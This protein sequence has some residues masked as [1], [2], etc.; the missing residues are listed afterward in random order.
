MD[1]DSMDWG[2]PSPKK[3]QLKD[4]TVRNTNYLSQV[5]VD[6]RNTLHDSRN[7][8]EL[9]SIASNLKEVARIRNEQH[10]YMTTQEDMTQSSLLGRT[11]A[12]TKNFTASAIDAGTQIVNQAAALPSFMSATSAKA[13]VDDRGRE[14]YGRYKK[15]PNSIT[16][17]ELAYLNGKSEKSQTG[18]LS[19]LMA[20]TRLENM[21][22]YDA[23]MEDVRGWVG[24]AR[25][26]KKGKLGTDLYNPYFSKLRDEEVKQLNDLTASKYTD[27][28]AK[29]KEMGDIAGMRK[30]QAEMTAEMLK[31][32]VK[33]NAKHNDALIG[34]AGSMVP[35]LIGGMA[36]AVGGAGLQTME[37]YAHS[38]D[39]YEKREGHIP[40]GSDGW[41]MAGMAG[42]NFG[43]NFIEN[44]TPLHALKAIRK[45]VAP[46]AIEA[47]KGSLAKSSAVALGGVAGATASNFIAGGVQD[48]IQRG[49]G[50]L[51]TDDVT[52]RSFIEAAVPAGLTGGALIAG[53][54]AVGGAAQGLAV[55]AE[56]AGAKAKEIKDARA[57]GAFEEQ[58]NPDSEKFN[59]LE[60]LQSQMKTYS[61]DN[62]TDE[63]KQTAFAQMEQAINAAEV[64]FERTETEVKEAIAQQDKNIADTKEAIAEFSEAIKVTTDVEK[65]AEYKTAIAEME[66][67]IKGYEAKRE[68][69]NTLLET[70]KADTAQVYDAYD[71]FVASNLA[72][73]E[74]AKAEQIVSQNIETLV[75]KD[76]DEK[77]MAK[78]VD[79]LKRNTAKYSP[80]QLY[81][82]AESAPSLSEEARASI[83][84]LADRKVELNSKKD[85]NAVS[86]EILN[87][88][89]GFIGLNEYIDKIATARNLG[90]EGVVTRN[91]SMLERFE[92]GAKDKANVAKAAF[93]MFQKD[94]QTRQIYKTA[95]NGAWAI[96]DGS[97]EI[98]A[99]NRAKY[100]AL[101]IG[102]N[103]SKLVS[104][105]AYDANEIAK[106]RT[107][108][109]GLKAF[110]TPAPEPVAA[111]KA[112]VKVETPDST[113]EVQPA[114]KAQPEGIISVLKDVTKE[115]RTAERNKAY[116][117]Q[118][119]IRTGFRQKPGNGL[120]NPL[121]AR[122]DFVSS[123]N[124]ET[125]PQAIKETTG[126]DA[127]EGR[128]KLLK[129][130]AGFS[131][132]FR[133]SLQKTFFKDKRS[134]FHHNDFVQ[135]LAD[136]NGQFDENVHSA[137]SLSAYAWLAEEGDAPMMRDTD[138]LEGIFHFTNVDN[139]FVPK[140][141]SQ[142]FGH[143]RHLSTAA[144]DFGKRAVS[145]LGLKVAPDAPASFQGRLE[146]SMGVQIVYAMQRAG[147]VTI[148]TKTNKEMAA[149]AKSL[150][151]SRYHDWLKEF[152][153][154]AKLPRN[155]KEYTEA[156]RKAVLAIENDSRRVQKF[157][158]PVRDEK[159]QAPKA[160]Q[161]IMESTR[162]ERGISTFMSEMF[163]TAPLYRDPS[164]GVPADASSKKQ[165]GTSLDISTEQ[166]KRINAAQKHPYRVR[167]EAYRPIAYMTDKYFDNFKQM[168]GLEV[169]REK[170][171]ETTHA[172]RIDSKVAKNEAIL[173]DLRNARD[174]IDTELKDEKG[175]YADTYMEMNVVRTQRM[176]VDNTRLNTQANQVHRAIVTP[177]DYET[178]V[179]IPKGAIK[180]E[181]TFVQGTG[182]VTQL[183]HFLRA[184]AENAEE[185]D[186][187]FAN[188]Y[189]GSSVDKVAPDDFLKSF[190]DWINLPTTQKGI[191]AMVAV[192]DH[193]EKGEDMSVSLFDDMAVVVD[194]MGMGVQSLNGLISLAEMQK[195]MKEG[196]DEFTTYTRAG[197]DGKTNGSAIAL[198]MSGTVDASTGTNDMSDGFGLIT[199]ASNADPSKGFTSQY[200]VAKS[201]MGDLY[202][203]INTFQT[204]RW[205]Q[206]F[207]GNE[208]TPT[209]GIDALSSRT[210][211]AMDTLFGGFNK[212]AKGKTIASPTIYG[213]GVTALKVN[214]ENENL[215]TLYSQF[216]KI[217]AK[218]KTDPKTAH[219]M[220]RELEHNV[221]Q[222]IQFHNELLVQIPSSESVATA[223][224]W[225]SRL[226]YDY[227]LRNP[228]NP[229]N[230]AQSRESI[231][232]QYA[233][234]YE[235]PF[236]DV[237]DKARKT[238]NRDRSPAK[239]GYLNA[240]DLDASR[241]LTLEFDN[242][243]TNA[244]GQVTY[245]THGYVH[246]HAL[247]DAYKDYLNVRDVSIA[248]SGVAYKVYEELKK[249][250]VERVTQEG[251]EDG[252]IPF[253]MEDG[254]RVAQVGLSE[255]AL[256]QVEKEL[257]M[258]RP[259]VVSAM[260]S[261]SKDPVGTGIM[262][263]DTKAVS[264]KDSAHFVNS[265]VNSVDNE[266]KASTNE[267]GVKVYTDG[268][269]GVRI[270]VF[271]VLGTDATISSSTFNLDFAV[272]NMHDANYGPLDK[273]GDLGRQQNQEFHDTAATYHMQVEIMNT[274]MRSLAHAAK[275]DSL[276]PESW[277]N[278]RKALQQLELKA[279]GT[280]GKVGIAEL[281][282]KITDDRYA[283]EE[284]K[285]DYLDSLHTIHQY[286]AL[287]GQVV[288][289]E[290]H[291]ATRDAARKALRAERKGPAESRLVTVTKFLENRL[292]NKGNKT[293]SSPEPKE[294]NPVLD[295]LEGLGDKGGDAKEV[296]KLLGKTFNKNKALRQLVDAMKDV[297]GDSISIKLISETDSK[298]GPESVA[299]YSLK[300]NA[301]YVVREGVI[302]AKDLEETLLHEM[303]HATT[304]HTIEAVKAG[305][306]SEEA[307]A[308]YDRLEKLRNDIIAQLS[309]LERQAYDHHLSDVHELVAYGLSDA[310]FKQMLASKTVQA[311]GRT[312]SS[313]FRNLVNAILDLAFGTNYRKANRT[314]LPA[315]E[316]LVM[317]VSHILEEGKTRKNAL[318]DFEESVGQV[319]KV[320]NQ[321]RE[322]V[323]NMSA[324][325]VFRALPEGN[326]SPAFTKRLESLLGDVADR[327][328][329]KRPELADKVSDPQTRS[330]GALSAGF[331][332][333]DR[334]A[335]AVEVFEA[336]L[337]AAME[338]GRSTAVMRVMTSTYNEARKSLKPQDFLKGDWSTASAL[339]K[340]VAQAQYNYLFKPST[341][342]GRNT[343]IA[344][345][346]AMSMGSEKVAEMMNFVAEP[347][348]ARE[349]SLFGKLMKAVDYA[350]SW[351]SNWIAGARRN[352]TVNQ[353]AERLAIR[354]AEID[355]QQRN[356]VLRYFEN[357][358]GWVIGKLQ[359]ADAG[360]ANSMA[361]LSDLDSVKNSR[362]SLVRTFGK[363]MALNG[364]ERIDG[365][366]KALRDLRNHE[367]PNSR[368]GVVAETLN[369]F[370]TAD[371]FMKGMRKLLSGTKEIEKARTNMTESVRTIVRSSFEGEVSKEEHK[372]L[373][374]GLLRSGA[375][376]LMDTFKAHDIRNL[377]NQKATRGKAISD[378]ERIVAQHPEG[379]MM[380]NQAKQLGWYM[381]SGNSS[382]GLVMN[383]RA[384]ALGMGTIKYKGDPEAKVDPKLVAAIDELASLYSMDYMSAENRKAAVAVMD[385]ELARK[386][387][388]GFMDMLKMHKNLS[389]DALKNRFADNPLSAIKGW[390]PELNNPYVDTRIA[391]VKSKAE[392]EKKGWVM[393]SEISQDPADPLQSTQAIY[394]IKDGG[395]QRR[396]S[397]VVSL[398]DSH[399]KGST[400]T[401]D[402]HGEVLEMVNSKMHPAIE[403]VRT[404]NHATYD[405]RGEKS[406]MLVAS[407]DTDGNAMHY[408]YRMSAHARDELLKRKHDV[409][410]LLGEYA[411]R[412]LEREHSPEHNRKVIE[413]LYEDFKYGYGKDPKAYVEIGPHARDLGA[414][415]LWRL[416]PYKT[417]KDME[418]IWGK[419]QPMYVRNDMVNLVF[420][421]KKIALGN[422]WN[423][424]A[425]QRS[426]VEN[427]Y[428]KIM[429]SMFRGKGQLRSYQI[430]RATTE[431]VKFVKDL[432]VLRTPAV[433]IG[434]LKANFVLM[435]A[436]GINPAQISRDSAFALTNGRAYQA[437]RK[438]LL[439][440]E[441]Q[442]R[443]GLGDRKELEARLAQL[444]DSMARNPLR[445]FIES[446]TMP[447]IVDDTETMN[448]DYGFKSAIGEKFSKVTDVI[449]QGAKT[450]VS[451]FLMSPGTVGHNFMSAATQYSD[452]MGRYVI[453]NHNRKKGLSH[454][455]SVHE[456][457]ETFI[458]YDLPSSPQV[459][460]ANDVG[461]LMFTKF[462]FRYQRVML[463]LM[464]KSPTLVM[465]Q[466]IALGLLSD[467]ETVV[468]PNLINKGL[469][470]FHAGPM[471]LPGAFG[472]SLPGSIVF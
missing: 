262:L 118:N 190:V 228:D 371:G 387:G 198:T 197:S 233:G 177:R 391:P 280:K 134:E 32:T 90:R 431:T 68:D 40:T 345:F 27:R 114:P 435:L 452:F 30:A 93:E 269:P 305:K 210:A 144:Q 351:A 54:H 158:V 83:R 367:N 43:M 358:Y 288:L 320:L 247:N 167:V 185:L 29:L 392:M 138:I 275:T 425:E 400:I 157:V 216:E 310:K 130:F 307:N 117:E 115:V 48:S 25:A 132:G 137:M 129:N 236:R 88:G 170:L 459:Q 75:S 401:G 37:D 110:D 74:N 312:L 349:D 413:A 36:T 404:T 188:K 353:K 360:V 123:L 191:D 9:K 156:Q 377:M 296:F 59:P 469:G 140:E 125:I 159:G 207:K 109:T 205:E 35:Y 390:M 337:D 124:D 418:E 61:A 357:G 10:N 386:D 385:R 395:N 131:N 455:E 283:L 2:N 221:N 11:V 467:W 142:T 402:Q 116:S 451:T 169:D 160:V 439:M 113:P 173:R 426:Y 267:V 147:Y 5:A 293:Q 270:S 237:W 6:T 382:P 161:D 449:P 432:I 421:Y 318:K 314:E 329:V 284:A 206:L 128:T 423:K 18:A 294:V 104:R 71:A 193:A 273:V 295:Y 135:F 86:D 448:D 289:G 103:S 265:R 80:D 445:E 226:V 309:P 162:S 152:T 325:D 368:Y 304:A 428:V 341:E 266:G 155:P 211:Q 189:V 437:D 450:G 303:L 279:F 389:E 342:G 148:M 164:L 394:V 405:P 98:T 23:E 419:N 52:A 406:T 471:T 22:E 106:T 139:A 468:D 256:E 259:I 369:E 121:I 249:A 292:E 44:A 458:N 199:K 399:L 19:N 414:R 200:D 255:K 203:T 180:F 16:P 361:K 12:K 229:M 354:L 65:V 7:I 47:A 281:L 218:F 102:A 178:S 429:D 316:A 215:N 373:A 209:Q 213:S 120:P 327:L 462:L 330:T 244:L 321:Q 149:Y 202:N 472:G 234:E 141:V 153:G 463:R 340:A 348:K 41:K 352:Q 443:A 91:L 99:D 146:A 1:L 372:G 184:V 388:N 72:R 322:K 182:E 70:V 252:S 38:S 383:A 422:L 456:A 461:L 460:W 92:E 50:S 356:L 85:G 409:A 187:E 277:E 222:M 333:T 239:A 145:A 8:T 223:D 3:L 339:D 319:D 201:G 174:Y 465:T 287:G 378:R 415:D 424:Q 384:I 268:D 224:K 64:K 69:A 438:E 260:S 171:A 241:I 84:S 308:A 101:D 94:G 150:G 290:S 62:A 417:R 235:K 416:L 464:R 79:H 323:A 108:L 272:E 453:Y 362:F 154:D 212:R 365:V 374:Y 166:A 230:T 301:V 397:G 179:A 311:D 46:Q 17:E 278:I 313:M 60:A 343:A 217:A 291:K 334:E 282:R 344:R 250:V 100:G 440:V 366:P 227:N 317:D 28:I 111:P 364:S 328:M 97:V 15:D 336:V 300:E 175:E 238:Y 56:I 168:L 359:G 243:T 412:S 466:S 285:L 31:N 441:S 105:L 446:G 26:D 332:L 379:N 411:G 143:A 195:A 67:E 326:S 274:M 427:Q 246:E 315:L 181:D 302:S 245:F 21:Q 49:W 4:A 119:L 454:D 13:E 183:G 220:A 225:V 163:G 96:N 192:M 77:T 194:Q 447:A 87:G 204:K 380:I 335:Y 420:G 298:G 306:G 63:V 214:A 126:K 276:S 297:V 81:K 393:V 299:Y 253:K 457:M 112:D 251:M 20:N 151:A 165:K 355:T 430:G 219:Q 370:M 58:I 376:V 231:I 34:E 53:G 331:G 442:L 381:Q 76:A 396:V 350:V 122:K 89:E 240:G 57:A 258:A 434:N 264:R 136:E 398:T 271:P 408:S 436:H 196:K 42:L 248:M 254:K 55:G 45:G 208:L 232:R 73:E 286:G 33:A 338:H 176:Q 66:S 127:T 444:Q 346:V 410:E 242:E 107:M 363:L 470:M 51:N 375:Y 78:A 133:D 403:K 433:L 257:Y 39:Q 95:K 24:N 172:N 186:I 407:Y 324:R 261:R 347:T 263:T 82:I 14:I